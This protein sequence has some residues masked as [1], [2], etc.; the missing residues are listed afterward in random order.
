MS[1]CSCTGVFACRTVGVS[2]CWRVGLLVYPPAVVPSCVG[3]SAC[4]CIGQPV[5]RPVTCD[6]SACWR[7][8]LPTCRPVG[9]STCWCIDQLDNSSIWSFVLFWLVFVN[10]V[11]HTADFF[12]AMAEPPLLS[13]LPGFLPPPPPPPPPHA[14]VAVAVSSPRVLFVSVRT[15]WPYGDFPAHALLTWCRCLST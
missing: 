9:V 2:A 8:G 11:E 6:T 3:V 4:C 10:F 7:F 5:Y 1:A 15:L 13:L 14:P 12:L